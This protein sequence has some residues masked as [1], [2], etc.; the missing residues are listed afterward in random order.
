MIISSNS[1][2]ISSSFLILILVSNQFIRYSN[3]SDLKGYEKILFKTL[4]ITIFSSHEFFTHFEWG[5]E[6]RIDYSKI[7]KTRRKNKS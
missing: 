3:I 6:E 1:T 5:T 7:N 2:S 4:M